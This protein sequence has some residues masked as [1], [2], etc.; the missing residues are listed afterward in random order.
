MY[1]TS[2][3]RKGLKINIDGQ[4]FAVVEFQFVKPGK[5]Q[6]FTR[7]RLKNMITGAVIDRTYKSGEKLD[8]ADMEERQMQYLY[9]DG[10]SRVFMDTES[11]EQ[12]SLSDEQLGDTCQYLLD[13]SMVDVLLFEGK[14]IGVTP[15]TFV[16]LEVVETEPGF[17]G[18]TSSNTTKP[19][20]LQT[21]LTVNVPLF[22]NQGDVLKID[23]R[24]GQ[25]SERVKR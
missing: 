18:D 16:E 3:I 25:Y 1:E 21:G 9:A 14:P 13:G 6:A 8:K 10:D 19:A 23:T 15:P 4:P 17:K 20:T 7:T 24:T 12:L 11:Y 22:V 2:D 5:G